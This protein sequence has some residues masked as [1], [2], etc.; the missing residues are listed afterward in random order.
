MDYVREILDS[1]RD[2]TRFIRLTLS[3]PGKGTR[4]EWRRVVLRPVEISSG[5]MIQAAFQGERREVVRNIAP[6]QVEAAVGEI[7]DAGFRHI[8]LH[9][10]DGDL[11]V[12]ITRKGKALVSRGKPSAPGEKP[13][14][15]HDRDGEYPLR[16]EED[17]FLEKLGITRRGRVR[18]AMQDKFRQINHFLAL[19]GHTRLVREAQRGE[20]RMVDCG[21]GRAFLTFA[22]YHYLRDELGMQV[23]LAGVDADEGV[24]A[25][26]AEMRD[27]LGYGEVELVR[28]RILDHTP[29]APP[30][31]VVSLHA[32]DT[33]TD[34]ALAQGV[35]WGARLI[36]SVPCCQHEL[37]RR[38]S[39][40]EFRAV[41]RHGILRERTADILTDALRAAALRVMGY[42]AEVIEF[43][44]PG[45]TA[46][47]LMIRAERARGMDAG[48]AAREYLA[49]RDYWGVTPCI[50]QLLGEKFRVALDRGGTA[51]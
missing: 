2:E 36:L 48:D 51:S 11:H 6:E 12:R 26:A 45:H 29:S 13:D 50:E 10:T 9:C 27:R 28:S 22:A 34:E 1:T 46:K 44:S 43:I 14:L 17:E 7:L 25:K 15:S 33:A 31:A 37:H 35:K 49:L 3:S 5:R 20:V 18:A 8:N 24:I 41:L 32:Y 40:P 4:A 19:L 16:P 42:R 30:H 23:R 21:C 38:L 39:R 47:N